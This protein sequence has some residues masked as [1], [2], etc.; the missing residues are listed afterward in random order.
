MLTLIHMRYVCSFMC[1]ALYLKDLDLLIDSLGGGVSLMLT[2][3]NGTMRYIRSQVHRNPREGSSLQ[4]G[5][6]KKL[7]SWLE[8]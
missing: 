3:S 7:L 6:P 8:R 5:K 1:I 2:G 4:N